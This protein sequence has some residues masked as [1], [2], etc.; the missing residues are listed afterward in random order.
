MS[1][2]DH[3]SCVREQSSYEA[4]SRMGTERFNV[5]SGS[6]HVKHDCE[7]DVKYLN[8]FSGAK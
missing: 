8:S 6:E 4:R 7:S 3:L 2:A 1:K 5:F